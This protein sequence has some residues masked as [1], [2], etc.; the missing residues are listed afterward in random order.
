M[1]AALFEA[2]PLWY[3]SLLQAENRPFSATNLR[4]PFDTNRTALS[5][6]YETD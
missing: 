3:F 4:F 5:I 1:A 6:V 2:L